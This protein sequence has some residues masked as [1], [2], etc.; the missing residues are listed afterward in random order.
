MW[1]E[2]AEQNLQERASVL[3]YSKG[4]HIFIH[5]YLFSVYFFNS[6]QQEFYQEDEMLLPDRQ[7]MLV[8]FFF[9]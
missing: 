7:A 4:F 3:I 6:L 2:I 5:A 8:L 9:I 1:R